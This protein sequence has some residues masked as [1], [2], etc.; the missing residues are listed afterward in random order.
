VFTTPQTES[1]VSFPAG[2]YMDGAYVRN[3]S[4]MV[5]RF[6]VGVID[7]AK[8][9]SLSVSKI[10]AGTMNS[11]FASAVAAQF[12]TL[13]AINANTGALT[14]NS[15]GYLRGGSTGYLTGTGFWMGFHSGV[16]KFHIGDPTG[17][18]IAWTGSSLAINGQV[19]GANNIVDGAVTQYEISAFG[20]RAIDATNSP[21]GTGT[22][23]V[24]QFPGDDHIT[25]IVPAGRT[26]QTLFSATVLMDATSVSPGQVNSPNIEIQWATTPTFA[27]GTIFLT[28][29]MGVTETITGSTAPYLSARPILIR[30]AWLNTGG[31]DATVYV[32]AVAY[33]SYAQSPG[34][35]TSVGLCRMTVEVFKK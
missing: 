13:S 16:P 20:N 30:S 24:I 19:V 32:R 4:A 1:G 14:I 26:A 5:A 21:P 27:T 22:K 31:T 33:Y 25:V 8:I 10:N 34:L 23:L 7:E 6:G 28:E 11:T 3:L 29:S 18:F 12:G 9:G 17:Q 15:S 35:V 2:V